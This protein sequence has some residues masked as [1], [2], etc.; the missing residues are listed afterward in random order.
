MTDLLSRVEWKHDDLANDLA[1]H[2]GGT[3]RL[4][5]TDMQLGPSGSVRPDVYTIPTTYSR[6]CPLAYECKISVADFRADV[7]AGKWQ[8]YLPFASAVIFAV[9]VGLIGKQDLPHG[10]GLMTRGPNGWRMVKSPTLRPV[11]NL[12]LAAWQKLLFDGVGRAERFRQAEPRKA[13][14]W[15]ARDVVARRI[16]QDVADLFEYAD[17]ARESGRQ[18]GGPDRPA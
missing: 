2:V 11:E 12:P 17:V 16:G 7:T 13:S 10:C 18:A 8:S 9:P 1:A 4:T 6:F 14:R 5:F 15:H 3:N